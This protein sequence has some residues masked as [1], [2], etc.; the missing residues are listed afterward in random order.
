MTA[1]GLLLF[2]SALAVLV[3][4]GIGAAFAWA[5]ARRGPGD[6]LH[7][8]AELAPRGGAAVMVLGLATA[9][10]AF[11]PSVPWTWLGGAC[12]CDTYGG[13]HVCPVH[14]GPALALLGP[15]LVA[16]GAVLAPA[17]R[18]LAQLALSLREVARLTADARLVEDVGYL[19]HGGAPLVFAAGLAHPR[20]FVDGRWWSQLDARD[21]GV[22]EAHERAH[23]AA[24]DT[25]TRVVLDVVLS[26]FAPSVRNRVLD[27]WT[28]IAEVRA[29]EAAARADG[30]PLF[31][32]DVLCRYAR[33]GAPG[34]SLAFG[35]RALVTRV[36]AL[37]AGTSHPRLVL[38]RRTALLPAIAALAGGHALHRLLELGLTFLS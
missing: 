34:M 32:A 25:R 36:H 31:V 12:A 24:G 20:L 21:R 29:D 13:L 23:L 3:S 14:P 35:R 28:I 27:D 37:V 8:W 22:I 33:A 11:V 16:A 18:R 26:A 10:L 1:I 15:V 4:R 5:W 6:G 2:V 38:G 30:D 7:P 9:L 17:V 19:D